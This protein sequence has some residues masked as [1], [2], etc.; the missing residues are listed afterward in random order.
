[1]I[2]PIGGRR[3]EN[4]QEIL[5]RRKDAEQRVIKTLCE[6]PALSLYELKVLTQL[7]EN[8]LIQAVSTLEY[9]GI[10]WEDNDFYQLIGDDVCEMCGGN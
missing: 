6:N 2:E 1:M 7:N 5:A 10:V 9:M 4:K 3:K 8:D